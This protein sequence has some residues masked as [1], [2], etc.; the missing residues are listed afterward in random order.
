MQGLDLIDDGAI[1]SRKA[2]F[3]AVYLHN[4]VDIHRPAA[5]LTHRWVISDG[6]KLIVPKEGAS[7]LYDI[8]N[9]PHE[10]KP[11]SGP[12]AGKLKKLL[13]AWWPGR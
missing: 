9:D 2:I 4:A 11:L 7:E 1:R 8:V 6:H 5:N 13:D 10:E 12:K 3:G